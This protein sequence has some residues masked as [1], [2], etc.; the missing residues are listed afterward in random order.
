H[1]PRTTNRI[2]RKEL[3]P[4][5]RREAAVSVKRI[6]DW[7]V[8]VLV[9]VFVCVV[10]AMRIETC[11][12]VAR[13]LS[14]L[15]SDVLRVRGKVVEEN[16]R[17]AFPSLTAA[18]MR[19]LTRQMW[20]HL[21][22][23]VCEIAHAPR[24][25]RR[26]NWHRM[27]SVH[28]RRELLRHLLAPKPTVLISGHF[29]NFE[30]GGFLTGMLGFP[31]FTVARPL[32]NVYLDQFVNRFRGAHGQFILPKLGSSSRI[33][34]VLEAGHALTLLG[35]QHA[36]PKG[37]WVDF[38][39]HPASSHK[40]IALFSLTSGAPLLVVY[41]RRRGGPLQLEL[42]LAAVVDPDEG[43]AAAANV[44]TMTQ[45]YNHQLEQIV[46]R[47]PEQYWWLHRRWKGDPPSRR[48]KSHLHAA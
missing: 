31:T 12:E 43:D 45:W 4:L 32:D 34:A 18:Q 21:L 38:F 35:D 46:C 10:Q 48:S 13:W 8:Y 39:G 26:T 9:R 30:L 17:R 29:G 11:H 22:L 37:C 5:F 6:L 15:A 1:R 25:I 40:A 16:L 47:S 3:R 19:H 2:R 42:G 27:V 28:Q 44:K 36:G 33:Q 7:F 23:M 41:C 20:E 24:K 14:W